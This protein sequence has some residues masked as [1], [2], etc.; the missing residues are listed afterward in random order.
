VPAPNIVDRAQLLTLS[1]PEMTVLVGGL[2]GSF[3]LAGAQLLS[4]ENES[5]APCHWDSPLARDGTPRSWGD[6]LS[7]Y[8]GLEG[9]PSSYSVFRTGTSGTSPRYAEGVD[10]HDDRRRPP[11]CLEAPVVV[12]G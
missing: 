1:A 5:W 2:I 3:Q 7:P 10:R 12:A 4:I 6:A 9:R 8:I 11:M